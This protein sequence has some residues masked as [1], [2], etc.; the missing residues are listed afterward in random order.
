MAR[1]KYGKKDGSQRGWKRGGRGKNRTS[2][3]RHPIIKKRRKK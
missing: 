2:S 3:C 1:S